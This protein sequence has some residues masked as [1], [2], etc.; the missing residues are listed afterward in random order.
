MKRKPTYDELL[1]F[2]ELVARLTKDGDIIDGQEYC[3]DG[4]DDEIDAL[5]GL[6]SDARDLLETTAEGEPK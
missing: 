3:A 1:R 2:V 6:I 5:Y 4:N